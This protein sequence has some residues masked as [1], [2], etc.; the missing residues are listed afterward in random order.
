[1]MTPLQSLHVS[2]CAEV[3]PCMSNSAGAHFS[4]REHQL[5]Q[6]QQNPP[7]KCISADILESLYTC[8]DRVYCEGQNNGLRNTNEFVSKNNQVKPH[9]YI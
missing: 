3:K 9:S 8:E 6:H 1:M 7:V 5:H 4:R 2:S